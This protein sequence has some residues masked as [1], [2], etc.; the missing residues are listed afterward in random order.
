LVEL[1]IALLIM[2]VIAGTAITLF[3]GVLD[4]SKIGAD[5][6]TAEAIKR[7]ILT[8]INAS[9]DTNFSEVV[10]SDTMTAQEFVNA[11][12]DVIVVSGSDSNDLAGSYGPFLEKVDVVP[13]Q[14]NMKGWDIDVIVD[15][16]LIRVQS[17]TS[18]DGEID[19]APNEGA[20][21]DDYILGSRVEI[22]VG[23]S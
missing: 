6:E 16:Q 9:N 1:L 21:A 4:S 22:S 10:T 3:G 15:A 23:S 14:N 8:Y 2:A 20:I 17:T 11:F 19:I 5:R 7:A 13:Q 18:D 12:A